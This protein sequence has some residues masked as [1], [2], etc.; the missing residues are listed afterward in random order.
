[1]QN[2][3]KIAIDC[4]TA[5]AASHPATAGAAASEDSEQPA[6]GVAASQPATAGDKASEDSQCLSDRSRGEGFVHLLI[7]DR[8][9]GRATLGVRKFDPVLIRDRSRGRANSSC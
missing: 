4:Q 6:T 3:R 9:R 2:K 7:R 1:M 5:V 8:S